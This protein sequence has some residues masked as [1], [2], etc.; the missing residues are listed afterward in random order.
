VSNEA[1]GIDSVFALTF[2]LFLLRHLY[3]SIGRRDKSR[4]ITPAPPAASEKSSSDS[5]ADNAWLL[6]TP[7]V[8]QSGASSRFRGELVES[9]RHTERKGSSPLR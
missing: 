8:D 7:E 3:L 4:H 1:I 5:G 6:W 9:G 2:F